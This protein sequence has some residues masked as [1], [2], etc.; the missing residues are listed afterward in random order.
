MR[1]VLAFIIE[2]NPGLTGSQ[3]GH[4][5]ISDNHVLCDVLGFVG[6]SPLNLCN[7]P[8]TAVSLRTR[9]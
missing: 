4:R 7:N 9:L 5:G 3:C 2:D 8:H 6:K 1:L